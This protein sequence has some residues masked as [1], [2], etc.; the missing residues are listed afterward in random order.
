MVSQKKWWGQN[1]TSH[2]TSYGLGSQC[3]IVPNTGA[4]ISIVPGCLVYGDQ[5]TG[6]QVDVKGWDGR[7]VTLDTAIVNFTFK[8]RTFSSRVAV[9]HVF[10][11][12]MTT[13]EQLSDGCRHQSDCFWLGG[14]ATT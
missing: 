9:A 1:P 7:P 3:K 13:A 6:E 4:E 14:G 11:N 12:G 8:G 2:T 5:L 10:V